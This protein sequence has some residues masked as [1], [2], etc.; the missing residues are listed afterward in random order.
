MA[1]VYILI[2][3]GLV[4]FIHEVGHFLAAIL[5]GV[6]VHRFSIGF[7]PELF[8]F[9]YKGIR[10]SLCMIPLG[11]YVKLEGEEYGGQYIGFQ[12]KPVYVKVFVA[13]SGIVMNYILAFFVFFVV[14]FFHGYS[15]FSDKAV[16]ADVIKD[17]PAYKVGM[18]KG[19]L[20]VEV[21]GKK[22]EKWDDLKNEI[23]K[24]SGQKI[25]LVVLRE[26][27]YIHFSIIPQEVE[28]EGRIGIMRE[29]EYVKYG[30]LKSIYLSFDRLVFIT[31][32]TYEAIFH[33]IIKL[34]APEVM[35][36][37]G[38]GHIVVSTA[39]EGFF[40]FLKIIGLISAA[41]AVF[42]LLPI[43]LLD[44]WHIFLAVLQDVLKFR[45]SKTFALISNSLGVAILVTILLYA[46]TSDIFRIIK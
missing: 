32:K 7:G 6:K 18:K 11:G 31:L 10:Y 42:N 1:F 40:D 8:G 35:G 21:D 30:F 41:V 17:M 9:Y 20:I 33:S 44:G 13:I 34:K 29:V 38:V 28:G 4:I 12:S 39:K 19:D 16:V 43:P 2:T 37:V 45:I 26:E 46:T 15:K 24:K 14:F 22:I 25:E 5:S 23:S 27:K 3:F 36:P